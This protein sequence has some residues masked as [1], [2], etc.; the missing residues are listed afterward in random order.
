MSGNRYKINEGDVFGF[1]TVI[2]ELPVKIYP[3]GKHERIIRVKCECGEVRDMI[4]WNMIK[5]KEWVSCGCKQD[6]GKNFY[7]HGLSSHNLHWRWSGMLTRCYDKKFKYYEDYGGRGIEVCDEWRNNFM[8]FY[9]WSIKNGYKK[10]LELDRYPNNNGNYE[11]TNCRWA[12]GL[13]NSNNRRNSVKFNYKGEFLSLPQIAR[14]ENIHYGVLY[15]RV[16][17]AKMDVSS[18][19]ELAKKNLRKERGCNPNS[20]ISICK[21]YGVS[22]AA[23]T[24][25]MRRRNI[26]LEEALKFYTNVD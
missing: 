7:Q 5:R 2:K 22:Y 26:S 19:V 8:S 18:A 25:R 1:V 11:P 4:M 16:N 12:T 15:Y 14:K 3:N 24:L 20:I 9:N 21:K 10:E 6:R 17:S 13:E 23:L